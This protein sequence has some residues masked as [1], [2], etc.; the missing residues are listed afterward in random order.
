MVSRKPVPPTAT[1]DT[2]TAPRLQDMRQE[3][4]SASDS[5]QGTENAWDEPIERK[6]RDSGNDGNPRQLLKDD[7]PDILRPGAPKA[8]DVGLEPH[9]VWDEDYSTNPSP[10]LDPTKPSTTDVPQVLRPGDPAKSETN[11]FL[12]KKLSQKNGQQNTVLS[13]EVPALPLAQSLSELGVSDSA[14]NNPW[15]P[16]LADKKPPTPQAL[17]ITVTTQL[18]DDDPWSSE[19]AKLPSKSI[20]NSN[21]PALISIP[22]ETGPAAWDEESE[23]KTLKPLTSPAVVD[24]EFLRGQHAWDDVGSQNKGKGLAVGTGNQSTRQGSA[25]SG[26]GGDWN[27]IDSEPILDLVST[28]DLI[29]LNEQPSSAVVSETSQNPPAVPPRTSQEQAT[30]QQKATSA[31]EKSEAY[32]IKNVRW[33]DARSTKNPRT[34]PILV[35]NANG[36]C[37]L[38]ALVNAL[39]LTTPSNLDTALVQVL[40][41]REQ[42]SLNLLLDAVFDELMSRRANPDVPLPDVTELYA[43][44]KGLHTGMNVNPRFIPTPEL[45]QAHKRTSLTHIHPTERG[46]LIPGTFEDTKEMSLYATFSIQ[47][48]HGW[49]PPKTAPVYEALVRQA[50]SYEDAQNILF[51]EEEL[52]EKLQGG[53]DCDG[54]SEEEQLLYQDILTIKSFLAMSATQ[55]TPWGL[56]VIAKATQPGTFAILFRN[57][58]FSTLYRH[59]QTL[60]LLTLVTDAGYASHDEIVWESLVDVNGERAEFFSGDFRVVGGLSSQQRASFDASHVSGSFPRG[61][62][63]RNGNSSRATGAGSDDGWTTVQG[64]SSNRQSKKSISDNDVPLSPNHEQEDRDLALALQLQEEEDERHRAEQARRQR[65]SQLSERYIEQQARQTGP[66]V[67]GRG[68]RGGQHSSRGGGLGTSNATSR[69]QDRSSSLGAVG[70]TTGAGRGTQTSRGRGQQV[71]PLVPP[72]RQGVTRPADEGAEDAP[73]SYEQAAQSTPYVPP[74][75]HPSHPHSTPSVS[76]QSTGISSGPNLPSGPSGPGNAPQQLPP[77]RPIGGRLRPVSLSPIAG[78]SQHGG[79]EGGKDCV[80]M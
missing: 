50:A 24:E 70:G 28:G 77:Q 17:P 46:D 1:I 10:S 62:S 66:A 20:P 40:R 21:S 59:P 74:V 75:G 52:E 6:S 76:R 51:R 68:G 39:S 4:W 43:F 16:A 64:R 38:V 55:L 33:Y 19:T 23:P 25:H 32:Q 2:A 61:S 5:D 29:D 7:T 35:Q 65:E 26:P 80:V 18:P 56:E 37:P 69:L 71:R 8:T 44:L 47:L 27:L 41:S 79:R 57:D 30:S 49:L 48:I 3:L 15:Q 53:P 73:P 60:E 42:V 12:R 45:T 14:S 67:G 63:E 9:N 36:P 13:T 34:S 22:S 72:A 31:S 54:L 11:P 58:H 78:G